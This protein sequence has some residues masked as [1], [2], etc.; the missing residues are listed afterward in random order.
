MKTAA[1]AEVAGKIEMPGSGQVV[2]AAAVAVEAAVHEA[3]LVGTQDAAEMM[4][5]ALL[6]VMHRSSQKGYPVILRIVVAAL[7]Q[8]VVS[9]E[10]TALVEEVET[11]HWLQVVVMP[12][13]YLMLVQLETFVMLT[14]RLLA[15]SDSGDVSYITRLITNDE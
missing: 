14:S 4:V 15:V 13:H 6:E 8:I 10:D 1:V 12:L 7:H 9:V 3:H 2:A 11:G 5:I